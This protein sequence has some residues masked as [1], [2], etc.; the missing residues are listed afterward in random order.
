MVSIII[1]TFKGEDNIKNAV[2]SVLNQT[3]KDLEVIVVDDNGLGTVHQINTENALS[4]FAEDERFKYIAHEHNK[5]G[6][7]A[8]NTGI[9]YSK[10]EFIGFLDDDDIFLSEKIEKQVELFSNVGLEYG[11]IYGAFREMMDESHFRVV[12]AKHN[13]DFLYNFLCDKIIACSSTVL[14]RRSVLKDVKGWDESFKRHQDLEFFARIAFLYKAAYLQEVCVE[15]RKLDRNTPKAELY[16]KY[17]MHYL[18]KMNYIINSFSAEKQRKL[19]DHH[20]FEI[21]KMYIKEGK[22]KTAVSWA[23]RCSNP[24]KIIILYGVSGVSYLYRKMR[25]KI[26]CI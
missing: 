14:I 23:A 12:K 21:G 11:M 10:G 6:S 9:S 4:E 8:R 22:L 25:K 15:K 1:P 24:A 26:P 13:D 3:Y 19:Y 5:N 18:N 2:E 20:Y 16:E 7:A 17:H